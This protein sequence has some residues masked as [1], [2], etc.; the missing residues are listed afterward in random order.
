MSNRLFGWDL[1]PGVTMASI[2]R[3]FGDEEPPPMHC[4]ACGRFLPKQPFRMVQT[5]TRDW[6]NGKV[7]IYYDEYQGKKVEVSKF[8]QCQDEWGD[9]EEHEPHWYEQPMA[10]IMTEYQYRCSNGHI[11]KVYE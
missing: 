5:I 9:Y 4:P 3:A 2:E 11:T 6:C 8:V 7:R 10:D 1:P